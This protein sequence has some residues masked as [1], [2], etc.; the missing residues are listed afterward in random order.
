M[1]MTREEYGAIVHRHVHEFFRGHEAHSCAFDQGPIQKVLP[2]FHVV[3]IGPGPKLEL[4]T[5]VSVGSGFPGS[6]AA[7]HLEFMTTTEDPSARHVEL[8]A[9]AAHYHSTGERLDIGHTF[10][11]GQAWIDGS[12]L[13][14]M[15]VS[16]PYPFGADLE[17]FQAGEHE[18]H[19]LWLLPITKAERDYKAKHGLEALEARFEAAGLKYWESR[20]KSVV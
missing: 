2:G 6:P 15:L 14:H 18:A 1:T 11:I 8:L 9:M 10:P 16:L 17:I 7:R 5:Y 20:R 19:I 12:S 4:S 13:D 3:E